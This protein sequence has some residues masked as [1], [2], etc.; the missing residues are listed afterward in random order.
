MRD[1]YA[2]EVKSLTQHLGAHKESMIFARLADKYLH[3][4]EVQKA[5]EICQSGLRNHPQYASAY[6]VLAKCHLALQQYEEAEKHLKHLLNQDPRHL[7]GHKLYSELMARMGLSLRERDSQVRI[8]DLDPLY[9][10][11]EAEPAFVAEQAPAPVERF[12]PERAAPPAAPSAP[13]IETEPAEPFEPV[14]SPEA[15]AADARPTESVVSDYKP[16]VPEMDLDAFTRELAA[17]EVP[18]DE[19]LAETPAGLAGT[20]EPIAETAAPH[21]E[22]ENDFE[23]EE[24]HFS[25]IL[26]DLFSLSH[27]EETRRELEERS[28]LQRA[29]LQPEPELGPPAPE[30]EEFLPAEEPPFALQDEPEYRLT[31]ESESEPR[32]KPN[33]DPEPRYI[34]NP[35]PEPRYTP[36]PEPLYRFEPEPE[37]A[38]EPEPLAFEEPPAPPEPL[39]EE[40]RMSPVLPFRGDEEWP[41]EPVFDT[42]PEPES[43]IRLEPP[44]AGSGPF[45]EREAASPLGP[46]DGRGIGDELEDQPLSEEEEEEQFS[47]FLSNLDRLGGAALENGEEDLLTTTGE[48]GFTPPW[49]EE[50]EEE[51]FQQAGPEEQETPRR[52][53]QPPAPEEEPM[54]PEEPVDEKPKEKFVTPTLGEIYAAQGQYAKAINVFE[55]LLKKNPENEWYRTKLEYLRKRQEDESK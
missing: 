50:P 8:H 2:A 24:V 16:P 46:A 30:A 21:H 29:A 13:A 3:L 17:L 5:I 52:P 27:D 41:D 26:D 40:R 33:Q 14:I 53:L 31:P 47:S 6:F 49:D 32:Y 15:A 48:K 35:D 36:Q 28:T 34:P 7:N 44:A 9:S 43:P 45:S 23:R 22:P 4:N 25:E 37:P 19:E 11:A 12:A 51:P 54:A 39:P 42:P 18:A 38:P 1:S 10:L 20:V 55:M